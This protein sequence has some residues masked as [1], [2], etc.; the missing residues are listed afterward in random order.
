M[1]LIPTMEDALTMKDAQG[2]TFLEQKDGIYMI[3]LEDSIAKAAGILEY[4]LVTAIEEV[5]M[6][7]IETLQEAFKT[8][9][10]QEVTLTLQRA[11]DECDVSNRANECNMETITLPVTPNEEGKIGTYIFPNIVVSEDYKIHF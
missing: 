2:K 8:Y 1:Q 7:S 3:P 6:N 9:S 4:D 10:S 5:S 11:K